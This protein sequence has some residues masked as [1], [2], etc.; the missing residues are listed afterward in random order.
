VEKNRKQTVGHLPSQTHPQLK[1]TVFNA[2]DV[3]FP[4]QSRQSARLSLQSS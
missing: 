3:F 2:M 4:P 1:T